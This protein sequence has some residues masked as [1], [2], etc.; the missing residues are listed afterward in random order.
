VFIPIL[1]ERTPVALGH[2]H[3][4]LGAESSL[5]LTVDDSLGTR[6]F[7]V[8]S[9]RQRP[10]ARVARLRAAG[11]MRQ[12]TPRRGRSARIGTDWRD[13]RGTWPC[14]YPLSAPTLAGI[15]VFE[16][17]WFGT[18][19][20][21]RFPEQGPGCVHR[22]AANETT[23]QACGRRLWVSVPLAESGPADRG[24]SASEPADGNFVIM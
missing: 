20:R 13:V 18:E 23:A 6:S 11:F 24:A 9:S 15:L 22:L 1:Q 8:L 5:R 10:T 21:A 16:Y 14:R 3:H 17:Y 7:P 19:F 4:L 2:L 12:A